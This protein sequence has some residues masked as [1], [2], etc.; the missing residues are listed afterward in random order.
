MLKDG[1]GDEKEQ[2]CLGRAGLLGDYYTP[3]RY[4][5]SCKVVIVPVP[6]ID[7][8]ADKLDRKLDEWREKRSAQ[9]QA[10]QA[11]QN[12]PQNQ[13]YYNPF[14]PFGF[15]GSQSGSEEDSSDPNQNTYY[16]YWSSNDDPNRQQYQW[17]YRR[18]RRSPLGVLGKIVMIWLII[19]FL[20]SMLGSC[21]VRR[22]YPSY[23]YGYTDGSG[24]AYSDGYTSENASYTWT[25]TTGQNGS[26]N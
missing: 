9:Q 16:Y 1:F 17:N 24:S 5:E 11:Y 2:V 8:L 18:P 3:A 20:L 15:Y 12:G 23:Y 21:S 4:C 19:Q 7:T 22:Y 6:E 26:R 13:G 10:R 14:D 25:Q